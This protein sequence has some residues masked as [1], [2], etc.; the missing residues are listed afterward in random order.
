MRVPALPP[1]LTRRRLLGVA[2]AVGLAGC[3]IPGTWTSTTESRSFE[4]RG[5][6][7]LTVETEDGD[8]SVSP[9]DGDAV[10]VEATKR[11]RNGRDAL[12]AVEVTA[13]RTGDALAVGVDRSTLGPGVSVAVDLDVAVPPSLPV[14]RVETANGDVSARD[15]AGDG[16]Y[17]SE[18]GDVEV[19]S[20]DGVATLQS[21][22]GDVTGEGL[23]AVAGAQSENGDVDLAFGRLP[24]D[25]TVESRNGNVGAAVPQSLSARVEVRTANGRATVEGLDLTNASRS[26][27]SVAGRLGDG[28]PTLLLRSENGDVTLSARD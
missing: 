8:V 11:T 16:T 9:G 21:T 20:I 12:D 28:G 25:A 17:R 3:S 18:N 7:A 5:A 4:T 19:Q 6:T 26:E 13:E 24:G 15:V 22:N 10:R 2:G 14:A 23:D 27:R 1:A